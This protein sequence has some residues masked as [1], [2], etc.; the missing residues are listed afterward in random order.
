M[1]FYQNY[2]RLCNGKNIS[3][4]AAA[5]DVGIEKSTVTRWS[6]GTIPRQATLQ[7]V[8]DYFNVSVEDLLTD[9]KNTP[10][11]SGE[12]VT[13]EDIKF[14]LFDGDGEITDEMFEE[15]KRFAKYVQMREREK[16]N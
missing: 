8:A 11:V 4:S 14:A 13:D 15:V 10:T 6:Q 16:K 12:G 7:K 5:I 3:P 1:G 9:S 2:L